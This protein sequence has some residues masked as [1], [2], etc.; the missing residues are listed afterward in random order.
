[1]SQLV[2]VSIGDEPA[3]CSLW[4]DFP[5]LR[6]VA[7]VPIVQNKGALI[8][9]VKSLV[10]EFAVGGQANRTIWIPHVN[11]VSVK[12][13]CCILVKPPS[14]VVRQVHFLHGLLRLIRTFS[15]LQIAGARESVSILPYS[16]GP[17]GKG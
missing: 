13:L 8:G 14:A 3:G 6:N 9:E 16:V 17:G 12:N 2:L 15:M 4:T 7:I 1:M 10:G 5:V 11:V